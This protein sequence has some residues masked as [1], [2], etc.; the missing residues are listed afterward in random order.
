MMTAPPEAPA[1]QRPRLPKGA[2]VDLSAISILALLFLGPV[3]VSPHF[4]LF[5]DYDQ[6]L[7]WPSESIHNLPRFFHDIRPLGDGRWNPVFHLLTVA[8]YGLFGPNAFFFFLAQGISLVFSLMLVYGITR[9]MSEGS[10]AAGWAAC[11][12]ILISAPLAENYFT[13]D[14]VEPRVVLFSLLSIGF[15]AWRLQRPATALL[16]HA[17]LIQFLLAGLLIFSKETGAFLPAAV[18]VGC[19]AAALVQPRDSR[20]L[21]ESAVYAAAACAALVLFVVLGRVLL[22]GDAKVLREQSGGLGRYL[23]YQIS[24]D[25]IRDNFYG[26]LRKMPEMLFAVP[27]VALG[28]LWAFLRGRNRT[29]QAP[30]IVLFVTG[31]AGAIY[32]AGMLLWRFT[33]LYYMLPAVVFLAMASMA[34]VFQKGHVRRGAI[35]LLLMLVAASAQFADRWRTAWTVLAQD[36]AKD[37][38]LDALAEQAPLHHK[39]AVAM[40]DVRSAEIGRSLQVYLGLRHIPVAEGPPGLPGFRV[41]NLIEGPWVNLHDAHRYDGSEA[42]PPTSQEIDQAAAL[43]TPFVLWQYS[44]R[45]QIHRVWWMSPL[46]SGDLLILPAGS[47]ANLGVSARGVAAFSDSAE[48]ILATRFSGVSTRLLKSAVIQVPFTKDY[49]GWKLFEVTGVSS[50]PPDFHGL[51][52]RFPSG[53]S[54]IAWTPSREPYRWGYNNARMETSAGAL[55]LDLE[56][57]GKLGLPLTI[58]ALDDS[59]RE[60]ATWPLRGR[61]TVELPAQGT[62]AVTFRVPDSLKAA[63]TTICFRI[64]GVSAP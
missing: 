36:R 6:L 51:E 9:W 64:F 27:I 18:L 28:M 13:L 57:N 44:P 49:L 1:E 21:K 53:W 34:L 30:Q 16:L 55:R 42:E 59:G 17:G 31:A 15:F 39:A 7:R 37:L 25:L 40:F 45:R 12:L 56:P 38:I 33:L 52:S 4:G 62:G 46:E 24:W 61:S 8:A 5:S 11:L 3:L 29:W 43:R 58:R 2:A 20:L 22:E 32:L 60:I 63:P 10:R 35:L 26:Y 19:A 23:T 54:A 48:N 50:A 14:K 47:P 41:Y